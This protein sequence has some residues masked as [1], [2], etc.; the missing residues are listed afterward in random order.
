MSDLQVLPLHIT[1]TQV[2]NFKRNS[3]LL[4]ILPKEVAKLVPQYAL[5]ST[6]PYILR[7][8]AYC[9]PN[10]LIYFSAAPD[11]PQFG[12]DAEKDC[13]I[14]L[15]KSPDRQTDHLKGERVNRVAG[16]F[17]GHLFHGDC[18]RPTMFDEHGV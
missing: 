1:P 10:T 2:S 9:L 12:A 13:S 7:A 15:E 16:T 11:I 4:A 3:K 5:M 8:F 18:F 6:D 17:C 14:C